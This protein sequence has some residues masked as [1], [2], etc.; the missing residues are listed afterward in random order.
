MHLTPKTLY[1]S[2]LQ[3]KIERSLPTDAV[4]RI[5]AKKSRVF[6]LMLLNTLENWYWCTF[7]VKVSCR[8]NDGVDANRTLVLE[9]LTAVKKCHSSP[10]RLLPLFS[11]MTLLVLQPNSRNELFFFRRQEPFSQRSL[12]VIDICTIVFRHQLTSALSSLNLFF[13]N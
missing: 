6:I 11:T 12:Y 2:F 5:K 3:T 8:E 9:L 1:F 7:A 4:Q 13:E 10:I